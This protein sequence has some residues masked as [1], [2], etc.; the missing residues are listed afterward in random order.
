MLLQELFDPDSVMIIGASRDRVKVGN[1]VLRNIMD[2]GYKGRI[3]PINPSAED[4]EGIR[5][6]HSVLESPGA[7]L[8]INCI[9]VKSTIEAID[10]A[11]RKGAKAAIV[12][13]AGFREIGSE[14]AKFEKELVA[15]C[16]KY[17]IKL[18]GPNCLGMINTAT[19]L[20]ASFA[21]SMPPKGKM[22]FISQSGAI[23]TAILD[24]AL[25]ENVGFSKFL[26]LGNK[27]GID[28]AELLLALEDDPETSVILIYTE[29]IADGSDFTKVAAEVTKKKPVILV[30]SGVTAAGAR[31]I[32][33]HTGALAGSDAAYQAAFEKAGIIR[34][35]TLDQLFDLAS[36]FSTQTPPMGDRTVII[37]NAGGPGILTADA[38]EKF[39]LPLADISADLVEKLKE[40][41]PPMASLHNPIDLI[42]DA[43]AERYGTALDILLDDP[44]SSIALVL[45]TPQAMTEVERTAE[46]IIEA[47][48]KHA[49][50][51]IAAVFMGGEMVSK[52]RK[53]LHE[54]GVPSFPYPEPAVYSLKKLV[55]YAEWVKRPVPVLEPKP[56]VDSKGAKAIVAQATSQGKKT[57]LSTEAKTIANLYGISTPP[58]GM[59]TTPEEAGGIAKK[60]G[61]PV[62]LSVYSPTILHK[63]DVGGVKVG[64]STEQEVQNGFREIWYNVTRLMPNAEIY[65]IEVYKMVP[66]GKEI[67]VGATHDPQF[68]KIV[69]FGLG[70]VYANFLKDVSFGLAPLTS[71]EALGMIQK[72][73]A[74]VLLRGVRGEKASD[75]G[76]LVDVLVRAS[77]LVTDIPEILDLDINPLFVYEQGKGCTAVDVKM[78]LA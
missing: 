41:L 33:S 77:Y 73:K 20:N 10:E 25:M 74:Y 48:K 8:V 14:G 6:Y 17:S 32:S 24:W 51:P 5:A 68:G 52:A 19:P 9:P 1:A 56:S 50:K 66:Q 39:G 13:S 49:E 54:G 60:I 59:A 55:E 35:E 15:T 23:C 4:V 26:S 47:K 65:G 64:L 71:A 12:V 34:A 30:K 18:L 53:M 46:L 72:T 28:E 40:K 58:G 78:T 63:T 3:V 7:E 45:L 44:S 42:G 76:S 2:S 70:G 11:G 43:T 62:V 75:V 38:C 16:S 61:F 29:G 69:M 57:V 67:I 27:A 36:V 22:A 37:T 21:A 31:A